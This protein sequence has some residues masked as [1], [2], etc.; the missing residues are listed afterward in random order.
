[1]AAAPDPPP[2]PPPPAPE[3]KKK[4]SG[5]LLDFE[6]NDSALDDALG[7]TPSGRSVYVPPAR[8]GGGSDVQD[9]LSPGD[10]NAA[11][12]GRIDSLRRC[13]SEQKARDPGA[14]GVLKM[15]WVIG[16]DGGARE[17]KCLTSEFAQGPFAQCIAGV[18][19]SIK[20]P[21]SR[22]TGQEVTFPFNF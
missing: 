17:V 22:T 8:R 1:V 20:F 13:V 12:A 5:D 9:K 3:P 10:I 18:V 2:P 19:K 21:R 7:Q 16:S 11:V 4:K 15:R 14:S 6:G